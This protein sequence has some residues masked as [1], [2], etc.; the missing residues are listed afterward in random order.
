MLKQI[1]STALVVIPKVADPKELGDFRPIACCTVLYKI[2]T[3]IITDRF[4]VVIN[5]L[6]CVNQSAFILGR[7]IADNILLAHELIRNYHRVSEG[8]SCAMKIDLKKAY[9]SIDW[10][11]I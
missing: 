3:K 11:Y 5:Q 2:I 9:D 1:N 6:V 7:S 8:K 10:D 4:N